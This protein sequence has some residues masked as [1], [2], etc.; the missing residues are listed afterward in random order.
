MRGDC[1]RIRPDLHASH[2]AAR[3]GGLPRIPS[4]HA[5]MA[6]DA[7]AIMNLEL[8]AR[9]LHRRNIGLILTRLPFQAHS[10]PAMGTEQR[11]VDGDFL[12]NVCSATIRPVG[13]TVLVDAGQM[14]FGTARRACEPYA[15]PALRPGF[16]GSAFFSPREKGAACRLPARRAS[17]SASRNLAFSRSSTAIRSFRRLSSPCSSSSFP[18][19]PLTDPI[20][21]HFRQ[22]INPVN[23]YI[24]GFLFRSNL[25]A[26]GSQV[27][28]PCTSQ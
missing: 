18:I 2:R 4:L 22:K 17:S 9:R 25:R 14:S 28:S 15:L 11:A 13:P 12:G 27:S 10:T 5:A 16:P 24:Q 19:T 26:G 1:D 8:G 7:A 6:A 20:A 21:T 3:I 23:R